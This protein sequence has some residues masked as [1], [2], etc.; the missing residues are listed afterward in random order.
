MATALTSP[1]TRTSR[2][3]DRL[4][5]W[6]RE[7]RTDAGVPLDPGLRWRVVRRLAELGP[8]TRQ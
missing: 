4:A 1:S 3:P 7:G 8:G 2:D 6:L 5:G